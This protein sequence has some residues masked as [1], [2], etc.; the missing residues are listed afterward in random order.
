MLLLQRRQKGILLL[1][2]SPASPIMSQK[3]AAA[4]DLHARF[5]TQF[6]KNS[7]SQQDTTL[8]WDQTAKHS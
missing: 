1:L 6:E 8:G 2:S 4:L 7:Q 3:Y 5:V